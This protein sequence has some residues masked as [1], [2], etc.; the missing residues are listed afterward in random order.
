M[1]NF[2]SSIIV[3]NL[4]IYILFYCNYYYILNF[5][6]FNLLLMI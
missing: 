5:S 1:I 6:Y 2:K 3:Y 4:I